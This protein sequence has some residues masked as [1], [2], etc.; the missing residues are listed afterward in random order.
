MPFLAA[1]LA[2]WTGSTKSVSVCGVNSAMVA[3]PSAGASA[4]ATLSYVVGLLAGNAA[5]TLAVIGI[6][7]P[8][9]A[10][11]LPAEREVLLG[12]TLIVLGGLEAVHG[13]RL[14]PHV[15]WAVPRKWASGTLGLLSFGLIRGLA[16]FNHS[17]FASMHAWL[18]TL[19]L[20]GDFFSPVVVIATFAVGLGLWSIVALGDWAT[21]AGRLFR[22]PDQI[23]PRTVLVA[24][25]DGLA[26][27]FIGT[28]VLA[29]G[30][31]Q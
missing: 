26:L 27:A 16:I 24:R 23:L 5:L 1:L 9:R 22:W 15:P 3:R 2:L 10:L 4:V 31:A 29:A 7:A 25:A 14:L 28:F 18:L 11:L 6:C 19:A 17:P 13:P 30:A 20:L 12:L 8:F 21:P